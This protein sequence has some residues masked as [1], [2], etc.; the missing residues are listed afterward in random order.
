[1]QCQ[2][3]DHYARRFNYCGGPREDLPPAYGKF[4]PLKK[5]PQDKGQSCTVYVPTLE[6]KAKR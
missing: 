4:H 3:C 6:E 2:T 5:L 1:M